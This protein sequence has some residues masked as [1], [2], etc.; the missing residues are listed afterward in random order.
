LKFF[1]AFDTKYF[2]EKR[3]HFNEK[4]KIICLSSYNKL[5]NQNDISN[6][7]AD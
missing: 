3:F 2:E 7:T 6:Q 5:I 1:I 4:K